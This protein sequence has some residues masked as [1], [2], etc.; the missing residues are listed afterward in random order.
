MPPWASIAPM[1]L[2]TNASWK[3]TSPTTIPIP[4]GGSTTTRT[5]TMAVMTASRSSVLRPD[6]AAQRLARRLGVDVGSRHLAVDRAHVQ[7]TA[8]DAE[9]DAE[10]G[11]RRRD[12]QRHE[13]PADAEDD[14]RHGETA[15]ERLEDAGLERAEDVH[16]RA[17]RYRRTS[18]IVEAVAATQP[19]T[20]PDEEA[21]RRGPEGGVRPDPEPD[22]RPHR[23]RDREAERGERPEARQVAGRVGGV[24]LGR[25]QRGALTWVSRG[26]LGFTKRLIGRQTRRKL[27]HLPAE[28]RH[29]TTPPGSP[30][31]RP[32]RC[33]SGRGGTRCT[34]PRP[35]PA[36]PTGMKTFTPG[37]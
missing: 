17:H 27:L 33:A 32:R 25:A 13:E 6:H 7:E 9:R 20:M 5:S 31:A 10:G 23:A 11:E 34:G 26:C 1:T 22:E 8:G 21:P 29:L 14:R 37:S 4:R 30:P 2:P 15:Q 28:N 16:A 35:S 36:T 19:S 12:Q 18:T 24:G 3:M